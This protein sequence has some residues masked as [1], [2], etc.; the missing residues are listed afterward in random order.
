[1]TAT[2]WSQT[3]AWG[4]HPLT[5]GDGGKGGDAA[6]AVTPEL[7]R[8]LRRQDERYVVCDAEAVTD[9]ALRSYARPSEWP[10]D[11]DVARGTRRGLG[12]EGRGGKGGKEEEEVAEGE[13]RGGS[14]D[15]REPEPEPDAPDA[16]SG[17]LLSASS[18]SSSWRATIGP[19]PSIRKLGYVCPLFARKFAPQAAEELAAALADPTVRALGVPRLDL[20][21]AGPA[22]AS[23]NLSL[24]TE[25]WAQ[26]DS[27]R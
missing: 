6:T 12:E 16:E 27:G 4:S 19:Y 3:G 26:E 15:A 8:R 9:L 24:K 1:M 21:R 20:A 10:A 17:D 2:D 5:F 23:P 14:L 25:T 18:S 11:E 13:A 7:V 22:P